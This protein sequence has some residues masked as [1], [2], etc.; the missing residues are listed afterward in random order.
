LL[1]ILL[2][3]EQ[4]VGRHDVKQ[5]ADDGSDAIEMPGP[6]SAA[7]VSAQRRE[8]EPHRV[9]RS[10]RIDLAHLRDEQK[11]DASGLVD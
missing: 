10:E 1:I 5:A 4:H 8:R 2:A 6:A 9:L 11:I 3:E 7:E